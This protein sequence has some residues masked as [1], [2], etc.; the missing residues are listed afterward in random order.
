MTLTTFNMIPTTKH[1][2]YNI[3]HDTHNISMTQDNYGIN[4]C[5]HLPP[6]SPSL[7]GGLQCLLLA[8]PVGTPVHLCFKAS[9]FYMKEKVLPHPVQESLLSIGGL[10]GPVP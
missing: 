9:C 8:R 5:R 10:L 2:T 4:N 6:P 3:Q 7:D 1:D